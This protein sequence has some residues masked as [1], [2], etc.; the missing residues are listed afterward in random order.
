MV[1]SASWCTPEGKDKLRVVFDAAAKF[2]DSCLNSQLI[3]GPDLTSS[4]VGVLLRFREELVPFTA[5]IESMFHQVKVPSEQQDVFRFL[6][7]PNGDL[8]APLVE[9]QM[10][11]HVFGA[12]SSPGCANF[13]LRRTATDQSEES[14]DAAATLLNN[15]YVDDLLKSLPTTQQAA[16]LVGRVEQM[17]DKGGFKLT[18]FIAR[19]PEVLAKLPKDKISASS[20]SVC[21]DTPCAIQRALGIC[22]NL[23][24]DTFGFKIE[25]KD[26]PL[27]RRGVLSTIG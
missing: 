7:W 6:W 3:P 10:T 17:C 14:P 13:A 19:D 24:N 8:N 23:Q 9:Y 20:N 27:T 11:V 26:T 1:S 12:V 15:F 21:I 16:E 22:W 5:D 18:K 4:L 25:L 2:N